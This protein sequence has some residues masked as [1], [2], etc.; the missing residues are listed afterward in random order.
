MDGCLQHLSLSSF[1]DSQNLSVVFNL[2]RFICCRQAPSTTLL[3]PLLQEIGVR[4]EGDMFIF[5]MSK[6]LSLTCGSAVD[7]AATWNAELPLIEIAERYVQSKLELQIFK[8]STTGSSWSPLIGARVGSLVNAIGP[9]RIAELGFNSDRLEVLDRVPLD[10]CRQWSHKNE[11]D[12]KDSKILGRTYFSV[13][14][15]HEA[16][17]PKEN[18]SII[19]LQF[20]TH[21]PVAVEAALAGLQT[22]VNCP[23]CLDDLRDPVT[24]ECGHNFCRSCIQWSWADLRGRFPCP[25]C[26]HPCQE[27]HL[28]SN[29]QLGRMIGIAKLLQVTRSRKKWQ[30]ERH[31]CRKH[32]Q[33]LTLFCEEDLEVLCP[34]CARSPD[35]EGHQVRPMEEAASHH[36]QRLSSYIE[37]LKQQVADI[38]K[39]ISIQS[40]IFLE[41]EDKVEKQ[42]QKLVSEFEHLTQSVERDQEAALSRLVE[43]EK[44]VQQNLRANISTF[45]GH[46][47]TLKALRKE[48]T[49]RNE[50]SDDILMDIKS[51]FYIIKSVLYHC[52]RLELPAV[53]WAQLRREEYS[54][55]PQYS[56]LE[57][58]IKF[59][60]FTLDPETAHP[61]LLVSEDKKSVTFVRKKQRV[62]WNP[63]RFMVDPVVLGSE[64]FNCGRHYWEVQVDDKPEW[65]VGVCE[66]SLTRK[67]NQPPPGWNS[68]W[69]IQLQNGDYVARGSVPVSLVLK[70]RPRGIGTYVGYK[71]GQVSFYSLNDKSHIHSFR[72]TFS[73]FFSLF[74]FILFILE[75]RQRV[76]NLHL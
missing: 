5:R 33:V 3:S 59:R 28:R 24:I 6:V 19:S 66:D 13:E 57:K 43:E 42:E 45:S 51:V 37:P 47:S 4:K 9:Q 27:R 2:R 76:H 61:H 62:P 35:H 53:Y 75:R 38:Q 8:V 49:E 18:P 34:L 39:L 64:G 44:D 46:I 55:P 1:F 74:Y 10:T 65:A 15:L 68:C 56:A 16:Q 52:E 72:D 20:F 40:K 67:R 11:Q 30:E 22:E 29:T 23:I 63:K 25:V 31:L 50:M 70:E 48:V 41:L 12:R 69:T 58:I 17:P 14:K 26:R 73:F 21:G 71:L 7:K 32:N 36:R 54:L 60:E